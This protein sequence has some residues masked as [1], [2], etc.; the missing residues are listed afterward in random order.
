MC[1]RESS[2]LPVSTFDDATIVACRYRSKVCA[3]VRDRDCSA[4]RPTLVCASLFACIVYGLLGSVDWGY[5][6]ATRSRLD[7]SLKH[8]PHA[9]T[10]R[11]GGARVSESLSELEGGRVVELIYVLCKTSD[12]ARAKSRVY[13]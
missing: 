5:A 8:S 10:R 2:G 13:F 4:L 9:A 7:H 3:C 12:I 1:G 11:E 6:V